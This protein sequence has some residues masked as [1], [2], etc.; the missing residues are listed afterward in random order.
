M[1]V[2]VC[3]WF[4]TWTPIGIQFEREREKE[5]S[6]IE[7][8]LHAGPD[9]LKTSLLNRLV[10]YLQHLMF[11]IYLLTLNFIATH[12]IQTG[13]AVNRWFGHQL[14][15]LVAVHIAPR[16]PPPAPKGMG[17][18]RA[19]PS[20]ASG[21]GLSLWSLPVREI[22][23][24]LMFFNGRFICRRIQNCNVS[25]AEG[26]CIKLTPITYLYEIDLYHFFLYNLEKNRAERWMF[27]LLF[28]GAHEH[29]ICTYPKACCYWNT[30]AN[31]T[32][33]CCL[34]P[35]ISIPTCLLVWHV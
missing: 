3:I 32:V 2:F 28:L 8:Y 24:E 31:S 5:R 29:T 30:F 33:P 23:Y 10:R 1:H 9:D 27:V 6:A 7:V 21:P 34:C 18:G 22:P 25:F 19:A 11:V 14:L 20:P 16:S 15:E 12:I 4:G 13:R 17:Q 35:P 26:I